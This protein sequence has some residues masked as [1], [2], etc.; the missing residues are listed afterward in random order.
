VLGF[1]LLNI[2]RQTRRSLTAILAIAFGI[3]ALLLGSGFIEW[4][5][6]YGR[7][8]TI[9]SQLGHVRVFKPGYLESG[10]ADPFA[11]LLPND[12]SQITK[13]ESVA[14]VRSL[15]PRLAFN[16]L[17]SLGESTI[18]F[19]G[20]G[21]DGEREQALS[22][23]MTIVAGEGLS[24]QD[25]KG[26]IIGQGLAANLG[27]KPGDT[28]VLLVNTPSGGVNAVEGRVRGLFATITKAYDDSALRVPIAMSRKLLRVSGSHSY[29]L[30]LDKTEHTDAVVAQLRERFRGE[31]LEFV[32]WSQMA[33]FYNKTA[34]LFSRQ[35][36]VVR[37]IIA[38]IIVLSISNSLM[39]SVM[40][41]TREIGT[42]MALGTKRAGVLRLFLAEG[43]LLGMFGGVIG[44][45]AGWLA[46]LGVSAIGIAM[47]APPG[48]AFGYTAEIM[49]TWP[50]ALQAFALAVFTTLAA[51]VYP[52][53]K[54]SRMEIVNALRHNR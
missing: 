6:W 21:V 11:Y 3:M 42:M 8:S 54:A 39:M 32:P 28:V 5:L 45:V 50:M 7:E 20:E 44:L 29:A 41:R 37:L 17:I 1:A 2:I 33:D 49:V 52:A 51:S 14:Q 25:P 47:P 48:M 4:N 40:E 30:L 16:G 19:I 18:S 13:I 22:R 9:H 35:V 26:I 53:W 15:A 31:P 36:S 10:L 27:A 34:E 46:A 12:V 23:S 43:A 24:P 38:L